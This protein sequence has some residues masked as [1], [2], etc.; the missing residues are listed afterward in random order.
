M[1]VVSGRIVLA[2]P[3]GRT[4][5]SRWF[6]FLYHARIRGPLTAAA[7][8]VLAVLAV[9][10][11]AWAQDPPAHQH[12]QMAA[13]RK[14]M[15]MQDGV[16]VA[17]LNHQG[18]ARGGTEFVAPNW[19]MGMA[20]RESGRQRITFTGM[21]SLDEVLVG[22]SGYRELFQAGE[23]LDGVPIVDHQHPHDFLMQL[24]ASWRYSL[25]SSTA[26]TIGGGPSAEPTLGPVAFMHRASAAG[27]PFA[28]L[29]HHTFDSTHVSFGVVAASVDRGR[30]TFEASAFNGREPDDNRW[31]LDLG[32]M[33][34]FAGRVW[35]RPTAEWAIQVSSGRLK[36]PEAPEPGDV[37]RTTAS[38]SWTR[39]RAGG[40]TAVSAGWGMNDA[41]GTQR[42][43]VFAEATTERGANSLFGRAETQQLELEKFIGEPGTATVTAFTAGGARRL[44]VWRGFEGSLAAALTLYGVPHALESAYG[45]FP[46]SAQMFF[47][48]R[49]PAGSMGRMWDHRML[50]R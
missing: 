40:F 41:H 24:A 37:Q 9:A 13:P 2:A 6:P 10:M 32:P 42:H 35:F 8:V 30:W 7:Q 5:S 48:L 1:N 16:V 45:S 31:D 19:W 43:S 39:P 46:V 15:L 47:R 29:G 25:G 38:A 17:I 44:V 27:L 20:S 18:G 22:R 33:D 21:L 3:P 12:G 23:S 4:R 26:V 14:W 36:E 34:S 49:L 11:P 28:P 50:A